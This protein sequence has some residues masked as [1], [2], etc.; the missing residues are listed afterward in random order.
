MSHENVEIVRGRRGRLQPGHFVA[1][2]NIMRPNSER[3]WSRAIDPYGR[4]PR[5]VQSV[6][7]QRDT[8]EGT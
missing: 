1:T 8:G 7:C 6:V 2:V 3:D 4:L 5:T